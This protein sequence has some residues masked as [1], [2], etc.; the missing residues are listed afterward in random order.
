[1][2]VLITGGAG[3]IGQYLAQ[4]LRENDE[5]VALDLLSP[6]THEDPEASKKRFPGEVIV[7]DVADPEAW[8]LLPHM[9]VVIHLAAE[10]GTGQS[11]YEQDRYHRVNVEGTRLAA[12]AAAQWG[13]PLIAMSSRAVY[14]NGRFSCS[15]HGDSYGTACCSDAQPAPSRESDPHH[16]VSVYGETK[17][18]GE[19]IVEEYA[20]KIPVSVVRPQNVVGYGQALHNPYTGVL[21]AFLA[22][23]REGRPLAV[24]GDGSATRDFIHVSDVANLIAWLAKNPGPIGE[25][26]VLNSGTGVR[27]SLT[28]LAE[29]SIAAAPAEAKPI[30][31]VQVHR[32]GDIDHAVADLSRLR[33]T[34]AP[35]P[36]V[37]SQEAVSD[38]IRRSWDAPGAD[39][40]AW[41]NALTE[42]G[43]RG[44]TT[45]S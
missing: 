3:F 30:E 13:A 35:L 44:L 34:G 7:G 6:Q 28:E 4:L 15:Q 17:S 25:V 11:M 37:T 2:T 24:Y 42:L 38:F 22:R 8:K 40:S 14:G 12:R 27:T 41:D 20:G 39:S 1:M 45:E 29:Y 10:T 43:D 31:Y 36:A 32:A 23:L 26:R 21:A 18:L 5:L 9:D 33:E 16:P 19:Q